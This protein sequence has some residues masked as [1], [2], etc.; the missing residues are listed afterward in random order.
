[1][2]RLSERI[3]TLIAE[4]GLRPGDRLPSERSLADAFTVSRASLREALRDLSARGRVVSRQGGGTYVAVPA[5][6]GPPGRDLA[7]LAPLM[8]G[9]S[10][11]WQDIMEIRKSLEGDMAF[12]AA[13]RATAEDKA[14]LHAA[15]DR[16]TR[17]SGP[18]AAAAPHAAAGAD[19]DFHLAIA[20]ATHNAVMH[21]VVGELF[22]LL[23]A[24]I[25]ESLEGLFHLP[26]TAEAL[27]AQ[28][29]GLLDAILCGDADAARTAALTHLDFVERHLRRLADETARRH[30]SARALHDLSS[31]KDP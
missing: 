20:E 18:A 8:S 27:D 17:L 25:S 23:E 19:A 6:P 16:L 1:M 26:G 24:S 22:A 5:S 10:G 3:E 7:A 13:L 21:R 11:Y 14:R 2:P 4:R 15:C 30:R 9:D 28:H 31:T 12:F 29:K